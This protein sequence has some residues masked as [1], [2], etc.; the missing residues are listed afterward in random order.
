MI[1]RQQFSL[2]TLMILVTDWWVISAYRTTV[3][4]VIACA[5]FTVLI[6]LLLQRSLDA[7]PQLWLIMATL[8]ATGASSCQGRCRFPILNGP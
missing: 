3:P 2:K 7:W 6:T 1:H 8:V 4:V 5:V